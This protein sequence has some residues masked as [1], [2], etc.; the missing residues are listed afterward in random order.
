M[1]WHGFLHK[2]YT[3]AISYSLAGIIFFV[4]LP[5]YALSI[6]EVMYDAPGTDA[7]H[8]WIELYNDSSENI[9]L[10]NWKLNE[11]NTNHSISS[12]RGDA[13]LSPNE[14]VILADNGPSFVLD[15]AGYTGDVYDTSFSLLNSGELL[16]VLDEQKSIK[17]SASY[18]PASGAAGDGNSLHFLSGI[19]SAKQPNPGSA[20]NVASTNTTT[21]TTVSATTTPANTTTTSGFV[22]PY[23]SYHTLQ[24]TLR[25]ANPLANTETVFVPKLLYN[26]KDG[27]QQYTTGFVRFITGDGREIITNKLDPISVIYA[28]AGVYHVIMEYRTSSLLPEPL[29][30]YESDIT[31]LNPA[32]SLSV[33]NGFVSISNTLS[34]P[35]QISGWKIVAGNDELTIAHGTQIA[36]QSAISIGQSSEF[37]KKHTEFDL[38]NEQKT[39][40]IAH[41]G[42]VT[43]QIEETVPEQI[44]KKNLYKPVVVN[45]VPTEQK[46]SEPSAILYP[47]EIVDYS[48]LEKP[49]STDNTAQ[50]ISMMLISLVT[51]VTAY[52]VLAYCINRF[53][54]TAEQKQ[55]DSKTLNQTPTNTKTVDEADEYVLVE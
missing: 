2:S 46:N 5:V 35:A 29:A 21:N 27:I 28:T 33:V 44:R 19:W 48:A 40:K 38:Y 15:Y 22:A 9:S 20:P 24:V 32:L 25:P 49:V 16:Q 52:I 7:N 26:T 11:S 47:Q 31:V 13:L 4:C 50:T 41:Y 45:S 34:V 14:Y 1:I 39:T 18:T 37:V 42:I 30:V 17:V 10:Q 12:V 8:E 6:T 51:L 3:K 55:M 23:K 53:V 43:S 36:Q 54:T